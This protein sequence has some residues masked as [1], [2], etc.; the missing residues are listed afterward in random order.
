[1]NLLV[2]VA[3]ICTGD[4]VG[5]NDWQKR[6]IGRLIYSDS[7]QQQGV[8]H[9]KKALM[10]LILALFTVPALAE[11]NNPLNSMYVAPAVSYD[12]KQTVPAIVVGTSIDGSWAGLT[13]EINAS[14][15]PTANVMATVML[16]GLKTHAGLSYDIQ[17][18]GYGAVAGVDFGNLV[19]RVKFATLSNQTMMMDNSPYI[20]VGLRIPLGN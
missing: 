16:G 11:Y 13:G 2:L 7:Y 9:M 14:Q 5:V 18:G 4:A 17:S 6:K 19:T 3:D 8:K 1:M 12:G 20:T 15:N 10:A